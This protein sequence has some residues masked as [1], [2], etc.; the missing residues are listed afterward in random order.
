M[1]LTF[2]ARL[3][4]DGAVSKAEGMLLYHVATRLKTQ[5]WTRLPLVV[6]TIRSGQMRNE[7]QLAAALDFLLHHALSDFPLEQFL[8][9]CGAG[10]VV[11]AEQVEQVVSALP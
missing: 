8:E 6:R 2:E 5:C 3:A 4:K 10:V 11:T 9:A 1:C 7:T